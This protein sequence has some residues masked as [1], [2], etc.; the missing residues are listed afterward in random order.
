MFVHLQPINSKKIDITRPEIEKWFSLFMVSQQKWI[1]IQMANYLDLATKQLQYTT[2]LCIL[3]KLKLSFNEILYLSKAIWLTQYNCDSLGYI[4]FSQATA[5]DSLALTNAQIKYVK[6]NLINRGFISVHGT[7]N[8]DGSIPIKVE[9]KRIIDELKLDVSEFRSLSL[10]ADIAQKLY[11]MPEKKCLFFPGFIRTSMKHSEAIVL[12]S[13]IYLAKT[14]P[15]QLGNYID[16]EWMSQNLGLSEVKCRAAL[17]SL[18]KRQ[19]LKSNQSGKKVKTRYEIDSDVLGITLLDIIDSEPSKSNQTNTLSAAIEVL[20]NEAVKITNQKSKNDAQGSKKA[21][22]GVEI[23]ET[24]IVTKSSLN[25]Q[26]KLTASEFYKKLK[27][28]TKKTIVSTYELVHIDQV[29][30]II[31]KLQSCTLESKHTPKQWIR[32]LLSLN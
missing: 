20:K 29:E 31:D 7:S 9:L 8:D 24:T 1:P 28:L 16:F 27:K 23:G 14:Q 25:K 13:L 4:T 17:K 11:A 30:P 6:R 32:W 10:S 5:R 3:R 26:K 15:N 18:E 2:I 12:Q 21:Q 22:S 19:L